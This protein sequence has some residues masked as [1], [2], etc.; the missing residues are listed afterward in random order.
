MMGSPFAPMRRDVDFLYAR[1]NNGGA[2]G[3]G[4]SKAR[5]G[6]KVNNKNS[7]NGVNAGA[8]AQISMGNQN[9]QQG[10]NTMGGRYVYLP[11]CHIFSSSQCMELTKV[12]VVGPTP[13][14]VEVQTEPSQEW[15]RCHFLP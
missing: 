5:G 4:D 14:S 13:V 12:V 15:A 11:F 1:D 10:G 8:G 7:M 6:N 9:S 3:G 2:S